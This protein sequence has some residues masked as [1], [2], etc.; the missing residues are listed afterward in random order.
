MS[1][2]RSASRTEPTSKT[3][4]RDNLVPMRYVLSMM[5]TPTKNIRRVAIARRVGFAVVITIIV[6]TLVAVSS[7]VI[8]GGGDYES[9]T[10]GTEGG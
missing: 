4:I 8:R 7:G 6:W 9:S 1:N 2:P 5:I 3:S 10:V